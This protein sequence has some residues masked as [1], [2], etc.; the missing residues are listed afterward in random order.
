MI[1]YSLGHMAIYD[2]V[3]AV[4]AHMII[5]QNPMIQNMFLMVF[6]F[7]LLRVSGNIWFW[8]AAVDSDSYYYGFKA[9]K[10]LRREKAKADITTTEYN[11]SI[12]DH[13]TAKY[14]SD[15]QILTKVEIVKRNVLA[16]DVKTLKWFKRHENVKMTLGTIGFYFIYIP[17][18]YFY[19]ESCMW[20]ATIQRNELIT[21]LPSLQTTKDMKFN[22]SPIFRSLVL[23]GPSP[24]LNPDEMSVWQDKALLSLWKE[25][26]SLCEEETCPAGDTSTS[27]DIMM[28]SLIA[29]QDQLYY[30]DEAYIKS[31]I[32]S[33]SFYSFMGYAP[34]N[35]VSEK[36]SVTVSAVVFSLSFLLLTCIKVHLFNV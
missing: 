24:L 27:K 12:K 32:S 10:K 13:L 2:I 36:G 22:P 14:E 29:F 19:S 23:A 26:A 15:E 8:S 3:A 16:K 4:V 7:L 1:L 21:D 31:K 17:C 33:Y 34:A 11:E 6:G 9:A 35:F 28:K 30:A 5:H 18:A 20:L 25:D